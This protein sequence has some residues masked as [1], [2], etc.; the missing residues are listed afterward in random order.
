MPRLNIKSEISLTPS[1]E[2]QETGRT[3]KDIILMK[4]DENKNLG[5]LNS[6]LRKHKKSSLFYPGKNKGNILFF[7]NEHYYV[8]IRF[9]FCIYETCAWREIPHYV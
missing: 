9:I 7:S 3:Y 5:N 6:N 8:S 1:L 2:S 4:E